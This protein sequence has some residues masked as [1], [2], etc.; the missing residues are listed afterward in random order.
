MN[1]KNRIRNL[2]RKYSQTNISAGEVLNTESIRKINK[3][4]NQNQQKRRVDAILN[5]VKNKESIKKEVHDIT[6]NVCLKDLCKNCKEELIISCIILYVQRTRN[7]QYRIDRTSLWNKYEITWLKYSL[8]VER[9]LQ[10]TREN[11]TYIKND[12][13]VDN[14][15]FIKW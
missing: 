7:P 10:W 14:E 6:K 8:I 3:N 9:L 13:K 11:K 15:D 4:Y 12:D 1:Y 5:N 2:E